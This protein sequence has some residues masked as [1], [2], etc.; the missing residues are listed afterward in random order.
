MTRLGFYGLIPFYV[1]AIALWL[2]PFILPQYIALD[3]HQ[4]ALAYGAVIAAYLSGI[5]AGG[6]FHASRKSRRSFLPSMLITLAAFFAIIPSGVFFMSIGAAWRPVIILLILIYL[7]FRDM[8]GVREGALPK[9][10]GALRGQLTL[11]AGTAIF[12]IIARLT[13]WGYF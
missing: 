4:I 13:M 6:H 9:W 12:L 11:F 1:C 3:F 10:Y 8:N 7:Y 2:S 5:G